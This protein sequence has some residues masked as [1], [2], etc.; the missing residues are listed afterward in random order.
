MKIHRLEL[1]NFRKF[2]HTTFR[3]HPNFN[4]FIGDN[5][6][7]KTAILDALSVMLGT[8]T[9]RLESAQVRKGIKPEEVR[10]KIYEKNELINVEPQKPVF[11][12]AQGELHGKSIEWIRKYKD[13]GGKAHEM[14]DIAANDLKKVENGKEISLPVL[15]YYGTG[16]VW[17]IRRKT[18][19]GKPDSRLVG[20]RGCL[21]PRSDQ[22]L[23][24]SWFKKYELASFQKKKEIPALESVRKVVKT[25]IPGAK[26]FY[27]DVSN[28]AL[29]IDLGN[30]E[31]CLFNNLSDGYRNMV[32]MVADIAHRAARL[33]PHLGDKAAL[34][35]SGV[36]LIDEIDLHLHPQW[37]RR[38]VDNLHQSFPNIQFIVTTHSPFII[39]SM[40]PGQVIDLENEEPGFYDEQ[41]FAQ[42]A[43]A[44]EYSNK[45]IEDITEDVMKV[46][47]PQRSKR[48][49]EMYDAAIEYYR[50]LD[51]SKNSSQ[52]E[53]EKAKQ[54]LDE[55]S[56]PFSDNIAYMA[57]LEMERTTAGLGKQEQ[58][59]C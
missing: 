41:D 39:Q 27:F 31:T 3:F 5:G 33:N 15:L 30:N 28:D 26:N 20:Y 51:D 7:G 56:A 38:V 43:P 40:K 53:K 19:I 49:Q 8:Y 47:L 16:R 45:S 1:R 58:E 11:L 13:R 14:T 42:P 37:Q 52:E 9:Q 18:S 6:K 50:I 10:V 22:T 23:F 46:E 36:V 21:D 34:E 24:E 59:N 29:M 57:F 48:Y 32:S 35:S 17:V 2:E 12:K 25:C 55:L 54:K 44:M 4:V